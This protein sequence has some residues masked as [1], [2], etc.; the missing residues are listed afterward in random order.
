MS[1]Q[2]SFEFAQGDAPPPGRIPRPTRK[3][4]AP[5]PPYQT[6]APHQLPLAPALTDLRALRA[7]SGKYWQISEPVNGLL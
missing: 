6:L 3:R 1:Q 2:M 7:Y 5:T 4:I